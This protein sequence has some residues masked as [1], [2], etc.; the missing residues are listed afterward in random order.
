MVRFYD[1]LG[2]VETSLP[3]GRQVVVFFPAIC[4]RCNADL[5]SMREAKVDKET[6]ATYCS[7]C[8]VDMENS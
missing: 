7:H 6:G 1:E 8:F 4:Y 5:Y 3:D 2:F